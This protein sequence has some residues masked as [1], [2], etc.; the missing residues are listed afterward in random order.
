LR[1]HARAGESDAPQPVAAFIS[2][3]LAACTPRPVE[4]ATFRKP[5]PACQ[6]QSRGGGHVQ[7]GVLQLK[8]EVTEGDWQAERALPTYRVFAFRRSRQGRR[9]RRDR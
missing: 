4:R 8:L 6:R 2:L 5:S 3:L 9:R 1:L 7:D